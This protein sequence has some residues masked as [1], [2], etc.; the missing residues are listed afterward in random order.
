MLYNEM[1][2]KRRNSNEL[3]T[4]SSCTHSPFVLDWLLNIGEFE[5]LKARTVLI[6]DYLGEKS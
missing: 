5:V 1:N 2:Y 3:Q 4:S 6:N